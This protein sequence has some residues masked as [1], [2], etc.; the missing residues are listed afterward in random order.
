METIIIEGITLSGKTYISHQLRDSISH[1][2]VAVLDEK[3]TFLPFL[4]NTKAEVSKRFLLNTIRKLFTME[5]EGYDVI[6]IE[7]FHLSHAVRLQQDIAFVRE[8][9]KELLPLSPKV[10]LLKYDI[11]CVDERITHSFQER[12]AKWTNYIQ[13]RI[14][15]KN[16]SGYYARQLESFHSLLSQSFLPTLVLDTTHISDSHKSLVE[17]VKRSFLPYPVVAAGALIFD[18]DNRLFLMQ[19]SGKYGEEW[20]VP[21]GKVGYHE[22]AVNALQREIVEETNLYL[23]NIEFLSYRDYITSGKHF[24]FLEFKAFTTGSISVKINEEARTYGW[25]SKEDLEKLPIALPTRQ[26]IDSYYGS[27]GV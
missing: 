12:D 27:R 1:L 9:E 18:S 13:D 10:V 22:K 26:L 21:G 3:D 6:L 25:F 4:H 2:K 15:D 20:I 16:Y 24:L 23:E 5:K 14:P 11:E 19:S 17:Q 7:R 8:V